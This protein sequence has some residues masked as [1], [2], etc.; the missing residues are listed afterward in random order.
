MMM[1]VMMVMVMVMVMVMM[2]MV[3]M[4]IMMAIFC[5]SKRTPLLT[6]FFAHSS[7]T[8][9]TQLSHSSQPGSRCN[10]ASAA[11]PNIAFPGGGGRCRIPEG[12][13]V[14]QIAG[15]KQCR[16]Q[17]GLEEAMAAIDLA[18][19]GAPARPKR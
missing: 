19:A 17:P 5:L 11:K 14:L 16:G 4:V 7:H 18:I 3:M 15:V 2:V 1:M 8:A 13:V 9:L 6:H 10:A 12:D